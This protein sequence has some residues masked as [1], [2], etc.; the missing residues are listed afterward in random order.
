MLREKTSAET[1]LM[2]RK[3]KHARRAAFTLVEVALAAGVLAFALV[4][5]IQVVVSGSEM[6]DVA[7]KQTIAMQIIHG[8]L[9]QVRLKDWSQVNSW[10][11]SRT[12]WV[13]ASDNGGSQSDNIAK[14]FVF[15]ANLP[16]LS[17]GF[18]CTRTV[19]TV[20][21]ELKQIT[22]TVTWTSST[23]RSYS[24]QGSTYVGKNGLYVTYQR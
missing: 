6:L 5:M 18:R 2:L 20:R 14:D 21:T 7:R 17:A 19:A 8:Q 9:D 13:D 4:G 15:G 24:R 1:F 10:P 22:F 12:V 3:R 23:G 11:A 16:A